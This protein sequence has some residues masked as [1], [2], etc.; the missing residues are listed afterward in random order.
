MHSGITR[1]E[2][3]D[4]LLSSARLA[5]F[6]TWDWLSK[7]PEEE[8]DFV[9]RKRVDIWRKTKFNPDHLDKVADDSVYP[10]WMAIVG[11]MKKIYDNSQKINDFQSFEKHCMEILTPVITE[12]IDRDLVYI[13]D[14][15]DV[16][17]YQCGSLRFNLFPD[18]NNPQRSGFHIANACYPASIFDEKTYL[19]ACFLILMKQCEARFGV[20][21]IGTGTWLNSYSRWL[22]LFPRE[23]LDNM[24][25]PVVDV[26]NHYGFWGQFITSGKT[27]NHKLAEK[28]RKTGELPYFPRYSWC[29]IKAMRAHL[30][31]RYGI[32]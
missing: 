28:L 12:R 29:T 30:K 21:E 5:L 15:I 31:D 13:Q 20:T 26:Q 23:W 27:F 16:E 8:F 24:G 14:R 4:Y 22:E 11:Q 2:H 32:C 1:E 18:K 19:P 6:F 25:E 7:H 3:Q 9:I 17:K 10:E